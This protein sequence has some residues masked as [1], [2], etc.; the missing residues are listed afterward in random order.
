MK[1]RNLFPVASTLSD[2]SRK[3]HLPD[4]KRIFPPN[5]YKKNCVLVFA[6]SFCWKCRYLLKVV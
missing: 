4:Y 6:L 2:Y 5:T 3:T 1:V